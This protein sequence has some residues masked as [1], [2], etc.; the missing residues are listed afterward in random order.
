MLVAATGSTEK[1][2]KDFYFSVK[3]VPTHVPEGYKSNLLCSVNCRVKNVA[4]LWKNPGGKNNGRD[5]NWQWNPSPVEM[6]RVSP[7]QNLKSNILNWYNDV[8]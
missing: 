7:Y 5:T 1:A 8:C 6:H 2:K 4:I 3:K